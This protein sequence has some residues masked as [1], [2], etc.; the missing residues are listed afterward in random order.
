MCVSWYVCLCVFWGLTRER[1]GARKRTFSF[2]LFC[3]L[4]YYSVEEHNTKSRTQIICP[5]FPPSVS[6]STPLVHWLTYRTVLNWQ[7]WP[8]VWREPH[9]QMGHSVEMFGQQRKR[10]SARKKDRVRTT[11]VSPWLCLPP[12]SLSL[13]LAEDRHSAQASDKD[14][15]CAFWRKK[16]VSQQQL[17]CLAVAMLC[18]RVCL[19]C[20]RLGC[21][22]H[23]VKN[24]EQRT[25]VLCKYLFNRILKIQT[26]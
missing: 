1:E 9:R 20:R 4:L 10:K 19:V 26:I 11:W 5:P 21:R 22:P 2:V 18:V 16:S 17:D 13:S 3:V 7:K 25:E 12:S 14:F 6:S 15:Q 8:Q 24:V 23:I